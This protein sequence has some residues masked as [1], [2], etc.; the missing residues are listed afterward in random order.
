MHIYIY[1]YI[2][3]YMYVCISTHPWFHFRAPCFFLQGDL[4]WSQTEFEPFGGKDLLSVEV[5]LGDFPRGCLSCVRKGRGGLGQ[6]S[7]KHGRN[8]TNIAM[9]WPLK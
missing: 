9:I 1:T 6:L 7:S 5:G 2:Y 3:I 8:I 4:E